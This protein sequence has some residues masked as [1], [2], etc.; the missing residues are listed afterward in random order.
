MDT[1]KTW[2]NNLKTSDLQTN[3]IEI[4]EYEVNNIKAGH[5]KVKEGTSIHTGNTSNNTFREIH[6]LK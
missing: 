4:N 1:K 5:M 2:T 6:F 3:Y